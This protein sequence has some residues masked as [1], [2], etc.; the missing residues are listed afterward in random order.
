MH[1]DNLFGPAHAL[2]LVHGQ[3]E[4]IESLLRDACDDVCA[5][6]LSLGAQYEE[7]A[8]WLHEDADDQLAALEG[9]H[10]GSYHRLVDWAP[11][12][13]SQQ[14]AREGNAAWSIGLAQAA[15]NTGTRLPDQMRAAR[16]QQEACGLALKGSGP[17]SAGQTTA[18]AQHFAG[19]LRGFALRDVAPVS[20]AVRMSGV[21]RR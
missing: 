14:V 4:L 2:R 17:S 10:A 8:A 11:F 12:R 7:P 21:R 15:Q 16:T 1:A 18:D 3:I 9:A 13:R 20:R 19:L 6:L 5:S